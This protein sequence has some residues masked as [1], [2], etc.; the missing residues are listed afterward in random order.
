M[1]LTLSTLLQVKSRSS[2]EECVVALLDQWYL[3]Y[4]EASWRK[5][6]EDHINSPDFSAFTPLA[7]QMFQQAVGWLSQWA[8]SR[9]F[10]LGTKLP[11]DT[12]FVIESLSDSTIYMAYY[13]IAHF[14]QNGVFDG[15]E[16]GV[17][18]PEQLTDAVW[19]YIFMTDKPYPEGCGIPQDYL[20]KLKAEFTFWYPLDLR[21]SGKDLIP[22]HLTMSLYNHAAI[23]DGAKDRLPRAFFT[24]GH[25]MVDSEKMA[26]SKGNFITMKGAVE[27]WGTDATRLALA[28]SGDSL[29][30]ANFERNIADASILRLTSEMDWME[31]MLKSSDLRCGRGGK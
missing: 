30:D 21:V 15:S 24:N 5:V 7:K 16:V 18:A 17:I 14:L 28:Q 26:K 13:T 22:N 4:G 20:D 29:D 10:G 31:T 3:D 25:V 6:V 12:Q 9:W 11:W 1:L 8:C 19:D 27:Y 2:D 23:W